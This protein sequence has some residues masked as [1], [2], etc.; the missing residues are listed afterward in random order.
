MVEFAVDASKLA[1]LNVDLQNVFVEGT[2]IAA[3][4]GPAVVA[5]LNKLAAVCRRAG[6]LVVHTAHVTRPD[7]ANVGVLGELFPVVKEGLIARGSALAAFHRTLEI[8]PGDVVLEKPRFGAFQA[9]DLEAILRARGVDTV[10]VGGVATNVCAE[11]TAREACMRDFRVFF[12]SDG[13]ATRD[14][15]GIP[16]EV[17]QKATCAVLAEA[18][19]Q[20]L[21]VDEMIAKLEAT[22]AA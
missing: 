10:I 6:V 11:T 15:N 1:L 8:V 9:T 5:R 14:M 18:F 21:T 2:P 22:R 7:G 19:A 13:T 3:P 16:R 4:D 12:L 20:V 17:L